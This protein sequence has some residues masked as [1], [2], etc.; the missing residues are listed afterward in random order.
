MREGECEKNH[1]LRGQI[2]SEHQD[3]TI[4]LYRLT[5]IRSDRDRSFLGSEPNKPSFVSMA[6]GRRNYQVTRFPHEV[7]RI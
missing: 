2:A 4:G 6:G 3:I 5:S 1:E 7:R